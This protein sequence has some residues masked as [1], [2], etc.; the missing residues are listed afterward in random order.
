MDVKGTYFCGE[1]NTTFIIGCLCGF[2]KSGTVLGSQL[3]YYRSTDGIFIFI[4]KSNLDQIGARLGGR[5]FYASPVGVYSIGGDFKVFADF[6]GKEV[7]STIH[8]SFDYSFRTYF[9]VPN[10]LD[11]FSM[12]DDCWYDRGKPMV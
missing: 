6:D 5:Y 10:I 4:R 11:T 9:L 1:T 2:I 12:G 8:K 7:L 3:L